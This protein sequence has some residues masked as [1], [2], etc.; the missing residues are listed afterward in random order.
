MTGKGGKEAPKVREEH[1]F[2]LDG[3]KLRMFVSGP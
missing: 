1:V 3:A 2:W